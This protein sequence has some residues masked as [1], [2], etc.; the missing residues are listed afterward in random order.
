RGFWV[1]TRYD[2]IVAVSKDY[3]TYSSETGGTSLEAFAREEGEA[4]KSMRDTP[5]PAHTRLR[6]LVNQGFTPRVVNTYEERIRGIARGILEQ[7]LQKPARD[8]VAEGA[9]AT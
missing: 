6:A 1:F 3:E 5:P 8:L 7:A 4:R 2:D 9:H